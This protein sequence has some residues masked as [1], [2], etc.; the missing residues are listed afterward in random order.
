MR[1]ALALCCAALTACGSDPPTGPIDYQVLHYDYAFDLETRAAAAAVSLQVLVPG[2]C[3]S[4]PMRARGITLLE[5]DGER[6]GGDIEDDVLTVCGAGWDEGA[7]IVLRADVTV[8]DETWAPSDVGYS[9]KLDL[10]GGTFQ[11]LVSWVGGCDRF[12]PCDNRPDQFATYRF[13]VAHPEGV[14][15]LC[16]GT[17][18]AGATQTVCSFD[19]AGGPTYSSFSIAASPSWVAEDLGDW[20]GVHVTFH[21]TPSS[22]VFDGFDPEYQAAFLAWMEGRFGP[23]PFGDELRFAVGPTHWSGFEHPGSIM[24]YDRL[25]IGISGYSDAINHVSTHEVAHMWAGDHTTLAGTYDFVWKEAMAEY[26]SFVFE[27]EQLAEAVSRATAQYWKRAGAGVAY[28]PVPAEQPELLDYYG[29]VYGPGP[30]VLFRQLEVMFDRESVLDA[31]ASLIGGGP[32]AI[33]IDDVQAALEFETLADLDGYFDAWVHGE[34]APT[35]PTFTVDAVQDG[36][37][38]VTVTPTPGSEGFGCN[39]TV[40]VTGDGGES[41]EVDFQGGVNGENFP[42]SVYVSD[43]PFTPTGHR[44]DIHGSCLATEQTA[45]AAPRPPR[46]NPWIAR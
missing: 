37:L 14:Q 40:E 33:S 25:G 28:F 34:G 15:V 5:L 9:E 22:G 18:E 4:I 30:M 42:A 16:P 43:T 46:I 39:F 23:Y 29:D 19:H 12:A 26:L 38:M 44:F 6:V 8:A 7:E 21:D 13:T 32:R 17:I 10:D 1:P 3:V 45:T 36:G 31:I 20:G 41:V 2:D 27:S 24:L 11:Y 35:W